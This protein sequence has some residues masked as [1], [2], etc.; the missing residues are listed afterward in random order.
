MNH[1]DEKRIAAK[2]AKIMAMLCVRN[3][4]LETLHAGLTPFTQ[5]GD[6]SDVFVLDANGRRIPWTEVSRI[7]E[8]EMRALMRDI[9]N[10]LY[11]FHLHAD[12]PKLQA[13]IER[14]M[15]VA[16]KWDEPEIDPRM[17]SSSAKPQ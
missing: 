16:S 11:T 14:W 17:I 5:A 7:D 15:G 2:L 4:Q 6:Y 13:T 3:T 10:R 1:D 9:V 8:D 12:E